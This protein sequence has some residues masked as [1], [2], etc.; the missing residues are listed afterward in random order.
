MTGFGVIAFDTAAVEITYQHDSG[1]FEEQEVVGPGKFLVDEYQRV[2]SVLVVP[3]NLP[4]RLTE[5]TGIADVYV[6]V[7]RLDTGSLD[8]G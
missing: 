2:L 6:I 1:V 3:E 5:V 8:E 4:W 7:L